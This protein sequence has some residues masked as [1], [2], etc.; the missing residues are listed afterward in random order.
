MAK[1]CG[2]LN[3]CASSDSRCTRSREFETTTRTTTV[4]LNPRQPG[5]SED[6][7]DE[8]QDDPEDELTP[9]K[10]K[11]KVVFQP[12][13]GALCPLSPRTVLPLALHATEAG[14][15][16]IWRT[17]AGPRDIFAK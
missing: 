8:D 9:G 1:V 4:G 12:T 11:V 13:F 6:D 15:C 5:P 14:F 17:C 2:L 7:Q 10:Q 3:R 16:R